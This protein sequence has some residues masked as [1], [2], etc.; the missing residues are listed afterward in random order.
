VSRAAAVDPAPPVWRELLPPERR[1]VALPSAR[2]PVIVAERDPMVLSYVRSALLTAPPNSALPDWAYAAAGQLLRVP[3]FWRLAPT[4]GRPCGT[5]SWGG[6]LSEFVDR[7]GTRLVVLQHSRDPD[8]RVVLLMFGP[9]RSTPAFAAKIPAGP[10]SAGSVLAEAER[11]RGLT[12]IRSGP[13]AA[14]VPT[15]VDVLSHGGLPVLVTSAQPGAHMLV[16]YHRRGHT[17]NPMAVRHDLSAAADWLAA[18]QT[19]TAG[20]SEALDLPP[21][22]ADR[23]ARMATEPEQRELV[24]DRLSG[25]RSRLRRHR[26]PS[27]F[28]HGDFWPG[29]LLVG[30]GAISGVV[31]WEHSQAVGNPVRDWA[32]FALAY[33][34]YLDRHT[35]PGRRVA[36][37]PGLTAGVTGAGITYGID[38]SGWY[39]S[40]IREFLT[41]GLARIG[42][43]AACARDAVLTEIAALATEASDPR[44][45]RDHLALFLTLSETTA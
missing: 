20:A 1:F 29:N 21:G 32:R 13:L 8:P 42:L 3:A 10:R 34:A 23:L 25:L 14:T 33:S 45:A 16:R 44:F 4:V 31:D 35:R 17:A 12:A 43:P 22:V 40:L 7:T 38:G 18:A 15:V 28:V 39:P 5:P 9:G 30:H 27:T 36:G 2:R 11:L 6:S 19:A 26:A 24:V 41:R 37:H